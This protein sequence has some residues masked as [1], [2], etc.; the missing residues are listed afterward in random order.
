MDWA[1]QFDSVKFTFE[2]CKYFAWLNQKKKENVFCFFFWEKSVRIQLVKI[3]F[4][5]NTMGQHKRNNCSYL[6]PNLT[7]GPTKTLQ[8]QFRNFTCTVAKKDHYRPSKKKSTYTLCLYK[9]SFIFIR[10]FSQKF[11][12]FFTH[13]RI[14]F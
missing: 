8:V 11:P 2:I 12:F 10:L 3:F 4:W 6:R 14:F 5:T 13:L 1:A 9:Y 7:I